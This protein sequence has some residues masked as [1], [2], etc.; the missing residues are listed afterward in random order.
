MTVE[1]I[2]AFFGWCTL[3]NWGMMFIFL[4]FIT[5]GRSWTYRLHGRMFNVPPEEIGKI[6]YT[7][8]VGYKA[9]VFVFNLVPYL[10]LR[11]IA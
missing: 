11:I 2:R 7:V 3:L 9:A 8:M 10:V 4:I 6:L 5:L 1:M